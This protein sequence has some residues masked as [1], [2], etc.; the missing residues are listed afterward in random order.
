VRSFLLGIGA[1]VLFESGHVFFKVCRPAGAAA[2]LE[3]PS[4]TLPPL[5]LQ[6]LG[7]A[8]EAGTHDLME[9]VAHHIEAFSPLFVWDHV[10]AL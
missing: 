3:A 4:M 6:F 5:L 7:L 2:A 8:L 9:S 10:A 1:G